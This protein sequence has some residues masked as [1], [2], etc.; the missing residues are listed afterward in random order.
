[1][2]SE[3]ENRQVSKCD[4]LTQCRELEQKNSVDAR[5]NTPTPSQDVE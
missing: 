4:T 3:P 2:V 5:V 1:M